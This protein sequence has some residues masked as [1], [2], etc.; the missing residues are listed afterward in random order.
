MPMM[1][2]MPMMPMMPGGPRTGAGGP[3]V[4][5]MTGGDPGKAAGAAHVVD[6]ARLVELSVY[7]VASLYERF[8]PRPKPASSESGTTTT[9]P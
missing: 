1:S 4:E 8:P 5:G 2:M 3:R 6:N 9:K 7:A